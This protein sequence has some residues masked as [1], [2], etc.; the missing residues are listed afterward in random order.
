MCPR[1]CCL[2]LEDLHS[3]GGMS[4]LRTSLTVSISSPMHTS[5][6]SGGKKE[7]SKGHA[8]TMI[9]SFKH[10]ERWASGVNFPRENILNSGL[11][12]A[13]LYEALGEMSVD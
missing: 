3:A 9:C 6:S 2:F 13:C 4:M 1:V 7:G 8:L 11:R 5:K 12:Y 10:F